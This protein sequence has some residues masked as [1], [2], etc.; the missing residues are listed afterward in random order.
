MLLKKWWQAELKYCV[1]FLAF[2]WEALDIFACLQLCFL[3][4]IWMGWRRW[5]FAYLRSLR[6]AT[7][8]AESCSHS[9]NPLGLKP[10]PTRCQ[11]VRSIVSFRC[12]GLAGLLLLPQCHFF[13]LKVWLYFQ[14]NENGGLEWICVCENQYHHREHCPSGVSLSVSTSASY[15]WVSCT[16]TNFGSS[17]D[18]WSGL[19][20]SLPRKRIYFFQTL[21]GC[22]PGRQPS[23]QRSAVSPCAWARWQEGRE[24]DRHT[25]VLVITYW[26][27]KETRKL[28]NLKGTIFEKLFLFAG[29]KLPFRYVK[30]CHFPSLKE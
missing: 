16:W 12:V 3:V 17:W 15:L 19:R 9:I 1:Q 13:I 22:F 24:A 18:F 2:W 4:F 5:S 21:A 26:I 11:G 6:E 25:H 7:V 23:T 20:K 30:V 29:L 28:E 27:K 10:F 14:C 8:S